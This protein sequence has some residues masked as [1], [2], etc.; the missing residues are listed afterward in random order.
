MLDDHFRL[1]TPILL[2]WVATLTK[3]KIR[4][5]LFLK[6]AHLWAMKCSGESCQS[7]LLW[8]SSGF[9]LHLSRLWQIMHQALLRTIRQGVHL[10]NCICFGDQGNSLQKGVIAQPHT[11]IMATHKG[12]PVMVIETTFCYFTN[13]DFS[14]QKIKLLFFSWTVLWLGLHF[15]DRNF[16]LKHPLPAM[17]SV[18]LGRG[19]FTMLWGNFF[20]LPV[21]QSLQIYLIFD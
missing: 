20:F 14:S 15:C 10:V 16:Q 21:V 12:I 6:Y 19:E 3:C 9:R 17:S 7:C 4:A 2:C 11:V 5:P 13:K 8:V 18:P 1:G